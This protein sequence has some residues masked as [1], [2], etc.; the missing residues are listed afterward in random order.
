VPLVGIRVVGLDAGDDVVAPGE[1][2]LAVALRGE[3]VALLDGLGVG[4]CLVLGDLGLAG[5]S[6]VA[7]AA[8]GTPTA[9]LSFSQLSLLLA[10]FLNQF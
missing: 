1:V 3:R 5:L 2:L 4:G 6:V 9:C 10:R 7:R 8:S